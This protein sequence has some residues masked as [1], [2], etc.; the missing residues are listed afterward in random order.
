MTPRANRKTQPLPA[1]PESIGELGP[2]TERSLALAAW[3]TALLMREQEGDAEASKMLIE[4][5]N[6]VP[7]MW[8]ELA[9]LRDNAEG[10]WL[11]LIAPARESGRDFTREAI[12]RELERVRRD[13]AGAD[14]APIDAMLADRVALCWLA[15]HYAETQYA[16]RLKDGMTFKEGEYYHKQCERAERR[17]LKAIQTL[18]TVRRLLTPTV[19]LNVAEKQINVTRECLERGTSRLLTP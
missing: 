9:V 8:G 11:D 17:L 19:Q 16:E 10:C 2:T 3:I 13:A 1:P 12:R 15:A 5:Y 6:T 7:R 14:P 18:A 4:V